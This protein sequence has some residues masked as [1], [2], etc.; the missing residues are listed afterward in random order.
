MRTDLAD[1]AIATYRRDGFL[2]I[3]DFLAKGELRG[4][5]DAIEATVSR[6]GRE[7]VA[8]NPDLLETEGYRDEV[9]TQRVNVWKLDATVRRHV[10]DRDLGR[11]LCALAGIDGI[12]LWHDQTFFKPPWGGA[13]AFHLDLPNWSFSSPEGIQIWIALDDAT[14]RNGCL[15]YLPGS[16]RVTRGDR[17]ARL[18]GT[19]DAIFEIY[20]ELASIEAVPAEVPA[21]GAVVHS[22]LT[23]H[24]AGTNMTPRWRRAMTCQYMPDGARF[25]GNPCILTRSQLSVLKAGDPLDDEATNPLVWRRDAP[26]PSPSRS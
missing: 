8:G 1:D 21:G 19:M 2:V 3:R 17:T 15:H 11:M 16:H 18:R 25:N 23:V 26:G 12:R 6:M 13:T 20:P 24:G 10:L 7:R 9:V 5:T 4:L 22:G 14:L